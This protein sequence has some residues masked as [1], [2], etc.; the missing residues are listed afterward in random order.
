MKVSR[1]VFLV[2]FLTGCASSKFSSNPGAAVVGPGYLDAI[3]EHPRDRDTQ[4]YYP[5]FKIQ[6]YQPSAEALEP[7]P[8]AAVGAE[9]AA[10]LTYVP[11]P[12]AHVKE[13]T[14]KGYPCLERTGIQLFTGPAQK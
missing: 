14:G 12:S 6:D 2:L 8:K 3:A 4:Y 1:F 7:L 11:E 13:I 5:S 10:L 9:V